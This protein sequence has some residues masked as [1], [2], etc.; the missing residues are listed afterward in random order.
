VT[1]RTQYPLIGL[2]QDV[3]RQLADELHDRLGKLGYEEIRPAH[4]CVFGNMRPHG[5]RL[6]DIAEHARIT[7]QSVGEI[8]TNLEQLGYVERI[9]DP[10]DRR[11]KLVR[12]TARGQEVQAAAFEIFGEIE[13]EW[14]ERIG[15]KK[16]AAL[17]AALEELSLLPPLVLPRAA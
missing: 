16:V 10:E 12:L 5:V 11:A 1:Q 14:G 4:G 17:R 15:K 7:K 8:V 3:Q 13:A 6:T 9:P 2:L